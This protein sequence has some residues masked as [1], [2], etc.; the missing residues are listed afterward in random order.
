MFNY[1][2]KSNLALN[3]NIFLAQLED[4]NITFP[5]PENKTREFNISLNDYYTNDSREKSKY[6][7]HNN[8]IEGMGIEQEKLNEEI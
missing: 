3:Q 2:D 8:C 1:K 7:L 6:N 5:V 4:I